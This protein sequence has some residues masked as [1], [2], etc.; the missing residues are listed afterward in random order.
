MK[1]LTKESSQKMGVHKFTWHSFDTLSYTIEIQN[2]DLLINEE[3]LMTDHS[4]VQ[5]VDDLVRFYY[6]FVDLLASQEF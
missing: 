2:H 3:L 5:Y 6:S 1:I 4:K